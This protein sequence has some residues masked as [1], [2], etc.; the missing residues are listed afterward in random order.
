MRAIVSVPSTAFDV[1]LIPFILSLT[2][3][4]IHEKNKLL[5]LTSSHKQL[6]VRFLDV[7]IVVMV[8]QTSHINFI[9]K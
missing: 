8:K 1:H 3:Q 4:T 9:F 5:N 7:V 2:C 6:I